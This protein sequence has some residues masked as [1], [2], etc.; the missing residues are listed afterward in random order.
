MTDR[1]IGAVMVL[2]MQAWGLMF[3]GAFKA[4]EHGVDGDWGWM[5]A[6]LMGLFMLWV[7]YLAAS[8]TLRPVK[9]PRPAVRVDAAPA[10][11][12]D[13]IVKDLKEGQA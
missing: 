3:I 12:F 8:R 7:S 10:D 5:V 1:Q 2:K 11:G 13:E 6:M 9:R 4:V